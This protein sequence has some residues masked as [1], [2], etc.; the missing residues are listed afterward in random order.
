MFPKILHLTCKNK[1]NIGN[2][3]WIKC[4]EKFKHVYSGYEIMLYDNNDIYN[5]VRQHYPEHLQIIKSVSNGG[6]LADTFRYLILYLKGGIYADMDCEPLRHIDELFDNFIYYHGNNV[7]HKFSLTRLKA[8]YHTTY[9]LNPCSKYDKDTDN[10]LCKGHSIV[11]PENVDIVISNEFSKYFGKYG[12]KS[13]QCCQWFIIAKPDNELFKTCYM[14]CILNIKTK[15]YL[16]SVH[17]Y[18]G[19]LLFSLIVN[20][21]IIKTDIRIAL[22]PPDVFCVGPDI[23]HTRNSFI[24]HHFTGSWH[25]EEDIRKMKPMALVQK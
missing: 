5:I 8:D 14:T 16:K 18:T 2:P 25:K 23:P 4:Y 15:K 6:A 10:Y 9:N 24:K 19:P 17:D 13:G 22:L 3:I 20:D 7:D 1:N 11:N 12:K 21:Y